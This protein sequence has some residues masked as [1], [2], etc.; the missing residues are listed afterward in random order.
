MKKYL[1]GLDIGGTKCAVTLGRTSD[2][3]QPPE[4][5]EKVKSAGFKTAVV[6]NKIQDAA[7]EIIRSFFGDNCSGNDFAVGSGSGSGHDKIPFF[8]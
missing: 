1:I 4:I 2:D 6:T 8:G 3:G 7:I 5:L